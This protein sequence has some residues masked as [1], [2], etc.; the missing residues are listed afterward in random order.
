MSLLVQERL[1]GKTVIVFGGT[2]FV[3]RYV[4]RLLAKEG[5]LVKVVSR[6]AN[7]G[8]FLRSCG[9][10]GQVVPIGCDYRSAQDIDACVVSILLANV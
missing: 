9:A 5:A 2:G 4:V 1:R 3:G 6:V 10:V 7:R 8:Y